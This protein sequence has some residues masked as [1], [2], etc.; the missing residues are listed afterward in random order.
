[1]R[2]RC[3]DLEGS[4]TILAAE[5]VDILTRKKFIYVTGLHVMEVSEEGFGALSRLGKSGFCSALRYCAEV[6]TLFSSWEPGDGMNPSPIPEWVHS[7][8]SALYLSGGMNSTF[9]QCK[10][11]LN[12]YC[13]DL[14]LLDSFKLM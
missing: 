2:T 10:S 5:F 4:I 14:L 9:P 12:L 8:T 3:G 13:V 7:V 6:E 1:M 11:A